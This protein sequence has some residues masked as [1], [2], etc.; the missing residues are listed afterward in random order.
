MA[1]TSFD[2]S[3]LLLEPQG[4]A[5]YRRL[6]GVRGGE[7]GPAAAPTRAL[8]KTFWPGRPAKG[9]AMNTNAGT[10]HGLPGV[11]AVSA[12]FAAN[13]WAAVPP[14]RGSPAGRYLAGSVLLAT[15]QAA[16]TAERAAPARE[17]RQS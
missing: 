16:G 11:V 15:P 8:A 14:S 12:A 6:T 2:S 4:N 3:E 17:G 10:T 7:H 5:G 1:I 9:L 13:A